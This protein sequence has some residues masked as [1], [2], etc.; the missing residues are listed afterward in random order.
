M[1]KR[2]PPQRLDDPGP[3]KRTHENKDAVGTTENVLVEN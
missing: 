1:S 2:E 3:N